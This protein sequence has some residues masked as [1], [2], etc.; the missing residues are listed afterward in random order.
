[1][2]SLHEC[3]AKCRHMLICCFSDDD[4]IILILYFE[5]ISMKKMHNSLDYPYF[6]DP[7]V[8][9]ESFIQ[10]GQILI[11]KILIKIII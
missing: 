10:E 6:T 9:I 1:V 4:N 5:R 2:I 7:A 8:V 3:S 11:F